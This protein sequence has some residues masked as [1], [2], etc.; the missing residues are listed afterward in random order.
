MNLQRRSVLDSELQALKDNLLKLSQLVERA[1]EQSM[2]SL[3]QRDLALAAEVIKSDEE[4]NALRYLVE[5]ASLRILATQQPLAIDLRTVIASIHLAVEL[6]RMG[7]H[8]SGIARIVK[9][10]ATED[11]IDSL[12]KLPKMAKRAQKMIREGL[13]AFV[14]QDVELA[15]KMVKRDQKQDRQYQ[16]FF[17]ETLLSMQDDAYVRRATF[18]LWVSHN[19]ERIGDRATNIAE[20]V[21][22][23]VTGQFVESYDDLDG[24]LYIAAD[25]E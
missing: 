18:L 9:R 15:H 7:D 10:M 4:I 2:L 21:V 17:R 1:I 3:E 22:F 23:M 13:R 24:S 11:E 5:E 19:L 6:E 12:Q 14:D 16:N 25:D 20:R 8:A